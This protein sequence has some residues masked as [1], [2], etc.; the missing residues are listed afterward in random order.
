MANS[1]QSGTPKIGL[2]AAVALVVANMVGVGVFTS[3]GF[4]VADVPTGFP[5][6][7]LWTVGGVLSLCGALCYAELG[8]MLPRSGGEY[9]LL[10]ESF[11][12]LAGFL[13]GWI[14]VTVG[15]AAPTA[16]AAAAFGEYLGSIYGDLDPRWFAIPIVLLVTGVHLG[17]LRFAGRFQV[18]FTAGKIALILVLIGAAALAKESY[19]P[20]FA[21]QAGDGAYI[22]QKAFAISLVY[23]MYAYTGWNAAAYIVGEI[24]NPQRNLPLAL[25]IGTVLVTILYVALNAAFLKA[26]P[27]DELKFQPE[28]ALIAAQHLFGQ[29]GGTLM[30][31]LIAFGLIS[32]ISSMTWAGPRVAQTMG[33]DYR[34]FRALSKVNRFGVPAR[35]ILLQGAVVIVLV[36]SVTFEQLILYI[37][38]LLILSSLATVAAVVWLRIRKPEL[39]RPFRVPGYPLT[40]LLFI[41]VS[42][43]MLWVLTRN[44]PLESAWGLATLILGWFFYAASKSGKA[45]DDVPNSP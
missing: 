42:V 6:L 29:R 18:A 13:A 3:L 14:S 2:T 41:V 31:L 32:S 20:G 7:L 35:A 19:S 37:E 15:F 21:P 33:E 45:P 1:T 36:A 39:P 22:Y 38:S 23:V 43:Y 11:H 44:H 12:P 40:P 26:A 24:R 5:I 30:G 4:Q 10:R 8:A 28:V 27:I 25:L 9:H 16:V 17:S 34:P